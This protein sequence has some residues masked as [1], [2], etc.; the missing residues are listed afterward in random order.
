MQPNNFCLCSPKSEAHLTL[1]STFSLSF[2]SST[3]ASRDWAL[4]SLS[5][6]VSSLCL[7]ELSLGGCPTGQ[8]WDAATL[9]AIWIFTVVGPGV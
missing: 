9:A 7:G 6:D 1:S 8:L 5:P 2:L 3:R 4:R